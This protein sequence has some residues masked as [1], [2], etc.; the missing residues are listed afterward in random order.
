[1]YELLEEARNIYLFSRLLYQRTKHQGSCRRSLWKKPLV[2]ARLIVF[3]SKVENKS[4]ISIRSTYMSQL[5]PRCSVMHISASLKK[6]W[7]YFKA[8]ITR[9]KERGSS[10][11]VTSSTC[12]SRPQKLGSLPIRRPISSS[13][14][15]QSGSIR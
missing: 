5:P 15:T 7:D 6:S 12:L 9:K 13:L 2:K 4:S 1:M 3:D 11:S 10:S 8:P 14:P